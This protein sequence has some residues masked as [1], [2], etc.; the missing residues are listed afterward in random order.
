MKGIALH[1]NLFRAFSLSA[2]IVVLDQAAK[3]WVKGFSFLG[4]QHAGM[5]LGSSIPLIHNFLYITYIENPGMAFGIEVGSQLV[6]A[7]LSLIASVA[8]VYYLHKVRDESLVIVIPMALLLG[9]ALG[10]LIDRMFYGVIFGYAPLFY[11]R[12]VDFMDV[13][14]LHLSHFGIFNIADAAVTIGIVWLILF[15][16]SLESVTDSRP[17]TAT[18]APV[19]DDPDGKGSRPS[20]VP[21]PGSELQH[22]SK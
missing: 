16:R 7:L 1:R 12:V 2:L 11:G 22:V 21:E 9:G 19:V 20:D 15:R 8:V 14:L 13:R 10:N 17:K 3:L 5:E 18:G 6:L 4:V